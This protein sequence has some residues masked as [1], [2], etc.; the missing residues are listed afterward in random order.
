MQGTKRSLDGVQL[1][2]QALLRVLKSPLGKG[3]RAQ[4]YGAASHLH[5]RGGQADVH[6]PEAGMSICVWP[7]LFTSSCVS[8]QHTLS[9]AHSRLQCL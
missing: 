1:L 4:L 9:L 6:Q 3:R 7:A 2:V 5:V 8:R